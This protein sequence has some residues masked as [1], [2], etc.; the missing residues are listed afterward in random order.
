MTTLV[1]LFFSLV[2]KI[3]VVQH[4]VKKQARH[5]VSQAD[6]SKPLFSLRH[7][8]PAAV[9]QVLQVARHAQSWVARKATK[10]KRKTLLCFVRKIAKVQHAVKK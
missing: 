1:L 6:F 8:L 3:V 4:V 9:L 2:R 7:K 5:C 10:H